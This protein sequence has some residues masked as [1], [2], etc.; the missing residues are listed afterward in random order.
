[1]IRQH[2]ILLFTNLY[3]NSPFSGSE[4]IVLEL[5]RQRELGDFSLP[6][7]FSLAKRLKKSPVI[8]AQDMCDYFNS[9]KEVSSICLVESVNGFL[10]IRLNDSFIWDKFS[11]FSC[12]P[13]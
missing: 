2:L 4:D 12:N 3:V 11:D 1:M 13:L 8:I 5:P 7:A 6:I 9:K 10:N